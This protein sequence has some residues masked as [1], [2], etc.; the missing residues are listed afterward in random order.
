MSLMKNITTTSENNNH[1]GKLQCHTK[2]FKHALDLLPGIWSVM[3]HKSNFL[4]YNEAYAKMVGIDKLPE[5]YL[6]GKSGSNLP[7][8]LSKSVKYLFHCDDI[9][10][11]HVN[12]ICVLDRLSEPNDKW[13]VIEINK[14]A[15]LDSSGKVEAIMIEYIDQTDNNAID[16]V[17]SVSKKPNLPVCTADDDSSNIHHLI[18]T[19]E[20]IRLKTYELECL[21]YLRR[22]YNNKEIAKRQNIAYRTLTYRIN[23]LKVKFKVLTIAELITNVLTS[24]LLIGVPRNIFH[25]QMVIIFED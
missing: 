4:Y 6:I 2:K 3:D 23:A 14:V 25:E 20:E 24:G 8:S 11:K 22:G 21:F 10:K 7:V 18:S 13:F 5:D 9:L 1:L 19:S 17:I 15:I 12:M 16:L